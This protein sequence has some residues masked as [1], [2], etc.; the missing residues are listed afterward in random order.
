MLTRP[1]TDQILNG[2]ADELT[3]T[4][5]PDVQSEPV[6]VMLGMMDQLLRGCAQR[7][8]HEIAWMADETDAIVV[9]VQPF[10]GEPEVAAALDALGAAPVSLHLAEAAARYHLASE[11]LAAA[12]EAAFTNGD[13]EGRAALFALLRARNATELQIIGQL[14]L[15]GRG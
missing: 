13:D 15:V 8:A 2:V 3:T 11:V 9:A 10:A 6:R 5:L 1:T 14:N 7:A 12:L 4:V